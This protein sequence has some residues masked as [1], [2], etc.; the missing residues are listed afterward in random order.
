MILSRVALNICG[1]DMWQRYD[2]QTPLE[3]MWGIR[4]TKSSAGVCVIQTPF[5]K[6]NAASVGLDPSLPLRCV[7]SVLRAGPLLPG[8]SMYLNIGE[9]Q[10]LCGG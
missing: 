8:T 5:G 10:C 6:Q 2:M 3:R 1:N 7:G 4:S 9:N